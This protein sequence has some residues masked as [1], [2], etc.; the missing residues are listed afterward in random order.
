MIGT[1]KLMLNHDTMLLALQ[2]YFDK[3][4]TPNVVILSVDV[5][6]TRGYAGGI[7]DSFE[8]VVAGKEELEPKA[9][10]TKPTLNG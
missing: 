1:N 4:M 8:V 10:D 7:P 3:R 6:S 5:S 9:T 2:E